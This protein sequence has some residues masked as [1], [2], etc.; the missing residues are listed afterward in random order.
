MACTTHGRGLA[1]LST[2]SIVERVGALRTGAGWLESGLRFVAVRGKIQSLT[3]ETKNGPGRCDKHQ[4][5]PDPMTQR[6]GQ[7]LQ[8]IVP[9]QTRTRKMGRVF[10]FLMALGQR[11]VQ[12]V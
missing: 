2:R 1:S 12:N 11:M 4:P 8:T 9:I 7:R 5:E 10:C 3:T 6:A